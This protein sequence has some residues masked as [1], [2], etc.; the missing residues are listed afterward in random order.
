[1]DRRRRR[2]RARLS[3]H[4]SG[5]PR[6]RALLRGRAVRRPSPPRA[7]VAQ[8][9]AAL[10]RAGRSGQA[11]RPRQP[12]R[13]GRTADA[14]LLPGRAR[15]S[16]VRADR[17]RRRHGDR[18]LDERLD[19]RARADLRRGRVRRARPPAPPRVLGRHPRGVPARRGHLRRRRRPDRGRPVEA[20][21]RAGLL[22]LRPRARREPHRGHDRR[23]L[24]LRPR[25]GARHL[26]RGGTRAAA[27]SGA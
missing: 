22:P 21:R 2:A 16:T 12:A 23:L 15:L 17:A 20:R 1:M 18:R 13:G 10:R 5:R 14:H 3:L 7:V 27:S 4:R 19:R 9:A 24:R 25:P 8:P 11:A 26:E 6:V